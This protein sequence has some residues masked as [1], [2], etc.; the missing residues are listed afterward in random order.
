MNIINSIS[1]LIQRLR[2]VATESQGEEK[3]QVRETVIINGKE[4]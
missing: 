3:E 2:G 4:V 1:L